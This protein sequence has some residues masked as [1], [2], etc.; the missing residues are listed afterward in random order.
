[1]R[2]QA[3]KTIRHKLLTR[4]SFVLKLI[5]FS[6]S[7]CQA[8][9]IT[10]P[11]IFDVSAWISTL[12]R[13]NVDKSKMLIRLL[14][15]AMATLWHCIERRKKLNQMHTLDTIEM[16]LTHLFGSCGQT[17]SANI[18]IGNVEYFAKISVEVPS[19]KRWPTIFKCVDELYKM[20]G[21]APY[22]RFEHRFITATSGYS[23]ADAVNF[24]L[25]AK[26]DSDLEIQFLLEP[27]KEKMIYPFAFSS[28]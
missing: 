13:F 19:L 20:D 16:G 4:P 10:F 9:A 14:L 23:T 3:T 21:L 28:N 11:C 27:L 24:G 18:P 15:P 8:N 17:R 5:K 6:L 22:S 26:N 1:M 25:K 12:S 7:G 2:L